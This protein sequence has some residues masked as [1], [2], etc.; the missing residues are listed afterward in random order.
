MV[1]EIGFK[2]MRKAEKEQFILDRLEEEAEC[3][4]KL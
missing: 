4:K 2:K 3:M 1:S